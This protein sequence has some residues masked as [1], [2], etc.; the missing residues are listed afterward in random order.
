MFERY[1]IEIQHHGRNRMCDF[2]CDNVE[3]AY[4]LR[5]SKTYIN[6]N[7]LRNIGGL[8]QLMSNGRSCGDFSKKDFSSTGAARTMALDVKKW[9]RE[10]IKNWLITLPFEHQATLN[11]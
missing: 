3:A 4:L 9:F 5:D 8:E 11:R 6:S 7:L 2:T 10:C 1:V